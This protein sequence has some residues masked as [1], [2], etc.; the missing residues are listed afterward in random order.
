MDVTLLTIL[1]LKW[2]FNSCATGG[3]G[4]GDRIGGERVSCSYGIT[5]GSFP[6]AWIAT[7]LL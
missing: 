5:R 6:L 1:H 2:H 3:S 4:G 7:L